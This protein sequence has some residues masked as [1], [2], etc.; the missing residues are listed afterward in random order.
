MIVLRYI[1]NETK[2]FVTFVANRV[3]V[4]REG[5]R[6]SQWR[7]IRSEANPADLASRGIKASE[8]KKLEVW[9]HGPDFLWKDSKEWLQQPADLH[10]ELSHQDEGEKKER[11]TVNACAEKED[12]WGTLFERFSIWEKLRRV[13]AWVIRGACKLL[14]LRKKSAAATVSPMK[15]EEKVAHLLLSDVEEAERSIVKYVQIQTFPEELSSPN[16]SKGPLTKLKPFVNQ[17][18]LRVGGRLDRADFSYNAKHPMILPGEHRVT[19]MIILHY[20]HANGHV[21][22]HQLLAEIRQRFWIVNGVS[23]IR[24]VLRQCH[25]CKRQNAAVGEQ[26]IAPLPAVIVSSDSHQLIY[27]FA[28]VG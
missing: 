18:V 6:P 10:Q 5:S 25:E 19:E 1:F 11:I 13:V 4:I 24:R 2:R 20:H 21:G 16:P 28:A 8:T 9:K 3:A 22:P 12:F 15:P 17:G 23:P 26:I 14:Q 7:H 27:P